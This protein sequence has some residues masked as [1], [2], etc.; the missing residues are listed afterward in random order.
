MGKRTFIVA[1]LSANHNH[2]LELACRTIVAAKEAGA[3]AVKIQ[4]YTP[5]TITIDCDKP[6]FMTDENSLWAGQTLYSLYQKAY[7][8]FEWHEPLFRFAKEQGILLFSTPFDNTAVDFLESLD[9]P[10]YKI[11]S[12]ELVDINL[13]RYAA[14]LGKPMILSIGIAT[15]EEI[16]EAVHVCREVGNHDITLLQCVSEY[17]AALEDMNLSMIP[18]ITE[19]FGVKAGLSDHTMDA[20]ASTI[21]VGLGACVIEKHFIL[22]RSLGGP[23]AAFSIEPKEFQKMVQTI[24]TVEKT[25]GKV[26]YSITP[27]KKINRRFAR[28]LFAVKDIHAGEV[29]TAENIRSIR[30]GYGLAPKYLSTVL[31]KCATTEIK[32][33]TPIDWK[34]IE[35]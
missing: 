10:I 13:I 5:D 29:L 27:K 1:E 35:E 32:R 19:R 30:P 12:F 18:D 4:S 9:N 26:D 25:I 14:R 7:T 17:P 24:R 20:L 34:L 15:E 11:A 22:D 3:D 33:G 6:C 28:S 8:P 2:D 21:G 23:D 16:L 31:G